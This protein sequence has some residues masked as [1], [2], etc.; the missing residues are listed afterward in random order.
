MDSSTWTRAKQLF[1]E[2]LNTR[3]GERGSWL[4]RVC[5]EDGELLDQVEGLLA[6]HDEAGAFLTPPEPPGEQP[7]GAARRFRRRGRPG[8]APPALRLAALVLRA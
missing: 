5:G 7:A 8:A 2:A 6:A 3:T 1:Q 4:K